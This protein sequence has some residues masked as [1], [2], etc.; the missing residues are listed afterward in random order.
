MMTSTFSGTT[1]RGALV[2][3]APL[4]LA[5]AVSGCRSQAAEDTAPA[6]PTVGVAPALSRQIIQWDDFSGHIE[7]VE[8]VALRPRV[9]GYIE[10][11]TYQEGQIVQR[12]DVLFEI[13]ARSYQAALNQ[14]EA[15]LARARTRERL[16]RSEFVRAQKLVAVQAVSTE[17]LE[18]RR[19]AVEQAQ[20]DVQSAQAAV[21]Q[22]RLDLDFTKVRA[23]IT[24]RAGRALVTVGNLVTADGQD[25]VLTTLVS[26][27]PVYVHF[28]SDERTYL[29]YARMS[30]N[31]E[32]P[33]ERNGGVPVQVGLTGEAGYPHAGRVDFIDNRVD[34][35]TGTIRVRATLPNPDGHLT[36]GLYARVRL[37]ASSAFDAVLIDDKAIMT[38]Q[39]R[40]YV[41]VVDE[42]NAAQRRDIRLGRKS[43]GLRVVEQGLEP[44][45]RVVVTGIQKVFF[46]GMTV[47]VQEAPMAPLQLAQQS[48]ASH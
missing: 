43:D 25:S 41:Y 46:P 42:Q 39:D 4:L 10:K 9:S 1:S 18:Q 48:N 5:L 35:G 33:D 44:G 37:Q 38:D 19:A 26:Q 13:D 29:R 36:P 27:D 31:G 34:T 17:M 2:L 3:L 11:I 6:A 24:G 20:A 7:A 14:A 23:P 32:R 22:N 8:S 45:E 12:G 47:A 28:D 16:A 15:E 30:R 21:A 40:K